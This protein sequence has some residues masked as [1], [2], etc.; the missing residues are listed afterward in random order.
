MLFVS[1]ARAF[2]GANDVDD[3]W[4]VFWNNPFIL[5]MCC[6]CLQVLQLEYDGLE[7]IFELGAYK[8][9]QGLSLRR[10]IASILF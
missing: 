2:D 5:S 4:I 3:G 9:Q 6:T 1:Y 7:E 8:K 10:I